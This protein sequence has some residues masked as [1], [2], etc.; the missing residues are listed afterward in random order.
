MVQAALDFVGVVAIGRNEGQRLIDC[1]AS[2]RAV[3]NNVVYVDS[4]S[5]DGSA[6]AAEAISARI[7]NL[8]LRLPFTAARAR[9]EGFA[10][11]MAFRPNIR[12]VQFIDGDC[13]LAALWIERACSFM[14]ANTDVAIACGRRR[15]RY[16]AASIYNKMLDDEWNTPIGET[17]A[18]GGD[19]L[20]R[21][22]AFETAGGFRPI[23]IAGEE[24]ELCA[25]LR[26]Q[27]WKIWRLNEEMTLHDAAMHK[28]GQWWVRSVRSGYG[29]AEVSRLH[30][31]SLHQ[32]WRKEVARSAFWAGALPLLIIVGTVIKPIAVLI[33]LSYP[34]QIARIA[35]RRGLGC[36][37]SWW[38]A[39]LSV[40]A[41]FAQLQGILKFYWKLW[42]N[43]RAR[44]IEY[45]KL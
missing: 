34:L 23:L 31:G 10:A 33:T 35:Q 44:L 32:P 28:F 22:K 9:N 13:I 41:K 3:T 39:L 20:V 25:R 30:R 12:F 38:S 27:G 36:A 11:L 26:A 5:T 17:T 40:P 45:K 21:V 15:E 43:Q 29:F 19:A 37:E 7:V 8:D 14:E 2:V 24:P 4:G 42:R 6:D 16:P 1:L 18:C